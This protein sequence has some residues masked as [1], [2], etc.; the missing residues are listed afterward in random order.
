MP[1]ARPPT[2]DYLGYKPRVRSSVG[3]TAFVFFFSAFTLRVFC[4]FSFLAR[5]RRVTVA[6][7]GRWLVLNS[8][9][10]GETEPVIYIYSVCG[11]EMDHSG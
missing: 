4:V 11:E 8:G 1:H 9:L 10:I 5:S 3:L 6:I 7:L 2:L